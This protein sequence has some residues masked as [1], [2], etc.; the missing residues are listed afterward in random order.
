V[1]EIVEKGIIDR[2]QFREGLKERDIIG[3]IIE[4]QMNEVG[5]MYGGLKG[6]MSDGGLFRDTIMQGG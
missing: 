3:G 6:G 2:D 4:P 1:C 5:K